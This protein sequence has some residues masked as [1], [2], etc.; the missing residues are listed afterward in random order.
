MKD[1]M[2]IPMILDLFDPTYDGG[3]GTSGILFNTNTTGSADLST[4]MKTY[5]SDYLIDLA[6]A[7]L[8]HDQFAQTHDIPR[9]G[10]KTIEFRQ[11]DPLPELTTPLVEGVTPEGQSLS[12]KN[13]TATV[14]QYGGFVTI[15]D[16]LDLTAIDKMILQSTKLIASQAGRTLDTISREVMN[17]GT[18]VMYAKGATA[19]HKLGYTDSSTNN[20]LTVDD[21]RRAVRWM[22]NQDAPK[23]N[24]YYIGIIHPNVK[25]DLLSDPKWRNPHEYAD[26]ENIYKGEIGEIY[27]VRFVEASRAKVFSAPNLASDSRT[28]AIDHAAGYSGA[29]TSVAFDGGTV[30]TDGL[31]GRYIIINGVKA[32]VTDSTS[33]SITFASTNFGT[34]A[35]DT[36]I[37]PGEAGAAGIDVYSTLILADDA[38]GTTKV[39]GGGL[40]MIVKQLGSGNDPLNQ[41]ATNGWKAMKVTKILIPQYIMRIESS[42]TP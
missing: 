1:L 29:I 14:A 37:Y 18:N 39:T 28:L 7:E 19:R 16:V 17:A 24:G 42:A 4:E 9:N 23:I 22:E 10:G 11:F 13:L 41:R 40:Q 34:I 36:V 15:S 35:D 32:L 21:V 31:N 3:S 38:Y 33:S 5:Y 20:N 8:V 25:Y 27:G 12:V 30:A 26:P 2:I 6:E